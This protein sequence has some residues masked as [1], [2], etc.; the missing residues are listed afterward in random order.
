MGKGAP[1]HPEHR[2]TLEQRQV[3]RQLGDASAGKPDHQQPAIPGDTAHRLV[4]QVATHRVVDH[5]G[6]IAAG[7]AFDLVLEAGF[8]VVDQLVGTG[9]LGHGQLLGTAGCGNH[10][11]AHGFA[12]FHRRQADTAGS[13]EHQ[14]GF[15]GL[16]LAALAERMHRGAVGH[17]E[18]RSGGEVHLRWNRQYVIGRHR[19]LFGKTAPPGQGHDPVA[20]LQVAS[21]FAHGA[22]H[23]SGFATRREWQWWLELVLAFDDQGVGKVDPGGLHVQQDLVLLRHRAG[24]VFQDQV[25]RR[26]KGFAQHCFHRDYSFARSGR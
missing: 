9:S 26:A 10:P 11:R 7:Q 20:D 23:A 21:L 14:Q 6:A 4:K 22:D 13:T 2:R 19:H 15:P 8:A 24:D 18:G 25:L 16:E 12:N 3:H 17:A 1:E 5:I